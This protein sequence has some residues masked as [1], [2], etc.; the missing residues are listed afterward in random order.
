MK[1]SPKEKKKL[2]TKCDVIE[3]EE[4]VKEATVERAQQHISS[5]PVQC[6]IGQSWM[7]QLMKCRIEKTEKQTS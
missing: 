5:R 7:R 6:R 3:V 2:E 4:I 1:E